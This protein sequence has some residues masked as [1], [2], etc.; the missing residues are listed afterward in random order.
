MAAHGP[1]DPPDT[2]SC[3]VNLL[4]YC[5]GIVKDFF[6]PTDSVPPFQIAGD[7]T[8]SSLRGHQE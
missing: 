6:S 8:L 3:L 7:C 1:V 5:I 4:S 2:S